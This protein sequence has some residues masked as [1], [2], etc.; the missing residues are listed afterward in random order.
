[1]WSSVVSVV[2]AWERVLLYPAGGFLVASMLAPPALG[3]PRL[4]ERLLVMAVG[5][6]RRMDWCRLCL[7]SRVWHIDF[8]TGDDV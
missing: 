4:V 2:Y 3:W 8:D 1:M 7:G 5:G 6:A